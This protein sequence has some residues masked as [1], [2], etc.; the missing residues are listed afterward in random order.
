LHLDRLHDP[1]STGGGALTILAYL[2]F[3][4][5]DY[6]TA[7]KYHIAAL[8]LRYDGPFQREVAVSLIGLGDVAAANNDLTLA[9]TY[10]GQALSQGGTAGDDQLT[11]TA[12]IRLSRIEERQRRVASAHTP[13]QEGL[14]L[15]R[16]L[17]ELPLTA[18]A[19]RQLANLALIAGMYR[20]AGAHLDEALSIARTIGGNDLLSR[21]VDDYARLLAALGEQAPLLQ[22]TSAAVTNRAA[23]NTLYLPHQRAELDRLIADAR[24]D[25]GSAESAHHWATGA[26]LTLDEA[27]LCAQRYCADALPPEISATSPPGAESAR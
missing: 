18:L 4:R 15:A 22:L 12:Q 1:A 17:G 7:H 2:A 14:A 3:R 23:N 6:D 9:E 11:A 27:L 21:L 26:A 5:G 24:R 19:Q 16:A 8:W 10:Y 25:L 13:A 20:Q